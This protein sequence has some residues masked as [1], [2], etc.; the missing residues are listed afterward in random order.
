[1]P[2]ILPEMSDAAW[3][4]VAEEPGAEEQWSMVW[5]QADL[6][7]GGGGQIIEGAGITV[8]P[9]DI[10]TYPADVQTFFDECTAKGGIVGGTGG[11]KARLPTTESG[12]TCWYDDNKKCWDF[13]TYSK[14]RYMGGNRGC[15]E[16]G[17]VP[18]QPQ[19]PA[20]LDGFDG[21]YQGSETATCSGAGVGPITATEPISFTVE[22][23][24]IVDPS[25]TV[26]NIDIDRS[27][28]LNWT[29]S[30][31]YTTVEVSAKFSKD[32]LTG[33]TSVAG[34]ITSLTSVDVEGVSFQ[35][36]CSGS[37]TASR[38]PQ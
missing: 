34:N 16:Q 1:M 38:V 25:G 31:P 4:Y 30:F 3:D 2:T 14:E 12:Y 29:W 19:V 35:V 21:F 18:E 8:G 7:I 6:V 11:V 32:R 33:S 15:P 37:F 26:G 5:T 36:S 17:L 20:V 22:G 23:N 27:G 28:N 24:Q 13:L 9:P 10:Y